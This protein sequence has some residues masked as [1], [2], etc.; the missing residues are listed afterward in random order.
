MTNLEKHSEALKTL[1]QNLAIYKESIREIAEEV[2]Q[3]EVSKYPL[4]I[5][6]EKP[7]NLGK[8]IIDKEELALEFSIYAS[9]LE[10]FVARNLISGEKLNDFRKAFKDPR[11][12][13]CIFALL[14]DD[15][16][17]IFSPYDE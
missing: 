8:M 10:E 11:S 1:E 14:G 9:T 6:S 5:A 7:V 16:G 17:F 12:F 15:A 4:F 2:L 3:H 13:V